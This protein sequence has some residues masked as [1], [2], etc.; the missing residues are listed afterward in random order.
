MRLG[1]MT[2]ALIKIS[3]EIGYFVDKV[4]VTEGIR[5]G[6]IACSHHLGRWRLDENLGGEKWSTAL[7][8]LR[9]I[10]PGKWMMRQ[11]HGVRPFASKDPDS[12]RIWWGGCRGA[13]ESDFSSA[14]RSTQRCSLLAPEG[15]HR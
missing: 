2:D 12:A 10:E 8:D 1:V 13:S 5:P 14:A 9:Q 4:W 7:V 15:D 11:V 6:I 3:T